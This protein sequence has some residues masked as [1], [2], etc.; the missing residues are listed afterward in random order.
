MFNMR[1]R[2]MSYNIYSAAYNNHLIELELKRP[3]NCEILTLSMS[4]SFQTI[5]GA[6]IKLTMDI[7]LIK[8]FIAGPVVSL[9]GSP[10]VSPVTAAL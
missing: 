10:T 7:S 9:K 5:S 3:K 2:K 8:M 4:F 6:I 1:T